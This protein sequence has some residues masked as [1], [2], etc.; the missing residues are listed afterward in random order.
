MNT[1]ISTWQRRPRRPSRTS[2]AFL[3]VGLVVAACAGGA[4]QVLSTVG[5]SVGTPAGVNASAG[6]R[7]AAPLPAPAGLPQAQPAA[8]SG[9]AA[10]GGPEAQLLK[11]DA[12]IV[13]TGTLQLQVKDLA[14]AIGAARTAIG[15]V[16]GYVG[17]S[18]ESSDGDPVAEITYRIP[19]ARWDDA[20]DALRR[21]AV[22]IVGENTQAVEVTGQLVDLGARI[23]NLQA[24]ETALQGIA[25]KAT[26][27]NDVLEVEARLTDVRGQIE[28]LSAQQAQLTDQVS[29]GTL[30]VTYGLQ[31]V[32]VTQAAKRWDAAREVDQ[33]SANL[34]NILQAVAAAGIWFAIVWLPILIVG[35]VLLF[36]AI[37]IGRRM[38]LRLPRN[39]DPDFSMPSS[40]PPA[41]ESRA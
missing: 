32:A 16:G 33:A 17:A 13:R 4:S 1:R 23:R 39:P 5:S 8:T 28:Q 31:I 21:L 12:R 29:Y 27:V 2:I 34:V 22:K 40:P 15:S 41:A 20:L 30:T 3:L 11:D 10:A 25:A 14:A 36:I 9:P 35:L 26:K 19:S 24:S 38:G 7:A 18:R 6:D 37:R